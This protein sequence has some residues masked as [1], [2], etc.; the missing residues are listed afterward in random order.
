[1]KKILFIL[2]TINSYS[3]FSQQFSF[4]DLT[5]M[6]NDQKLYETKNIAKGNSIINMRRYENYFYHTN[7]GSSGVSGEY[8]TDLEGNLEELTKSTNVQLDF[9]DGYDKDMETAF[10]WYYLR[11]IHDIHNL[12]GRADG[13]LEK[14]SR[15]LEVQYA[16]ESHYASIL[17]Q[18]NALATYVGIREEYGSYYSEYEYNGLIIRLIKSDNRQGGGTIE[19]IKG[20]FPW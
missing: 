3:C 12:I 1:M 17:K 10:T 14:P 7:D 13:F 5:A 16:N 2:F 19:I 20:D 11:I 9:A 6:I 8:P 15:K 4:Y 18:V